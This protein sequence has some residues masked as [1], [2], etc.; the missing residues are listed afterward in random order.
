MIK[1]VPRGCV[2]QEKRLA[3]DDPFQLSTPCFQKSTWSQLP[4]EVINTIVKGEHKMPITRIPAN[5][6]PAK[7]TLGAGGSPIA[8][9]A[10]VMDALKTLKANEAI[11]L[12]I[13]KATTD[14]QADKKN[15]KPKIPARVLIATLR[16]KFSTNG[17]DYTAYTVDDK[18]VIVVK[19]SK[20][21]EGAAG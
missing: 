4:P 10:E 14:R 6:V 18:E 5:T 9:I 21:A 8:E 17:L 16:K 20:K 1:R 15:G 2:E 3:Y 19:N 7:R 12:S 13:S 11:R